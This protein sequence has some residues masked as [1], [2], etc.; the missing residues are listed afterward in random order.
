MVESI[1]LNE[2]DLKEL[3]DTGYAYYKQYVILTREKFIELVGGVNG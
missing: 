3:E 2:F 1:L